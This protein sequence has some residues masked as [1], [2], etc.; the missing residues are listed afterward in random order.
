METV[1][2]ESRD[3]LEEIDEF[4]SW[5][6]DEEEGELYV[7]EESP[8][9]EELSDYATDIRFNLTQLLSRIQTQESRYSIRRMLYACR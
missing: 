6:E 8:R 1:L 5:D 4:F 3:E 2:E 7:F 9:Q